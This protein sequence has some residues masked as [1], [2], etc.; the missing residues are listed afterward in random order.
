MFIKTES[1]TLINSDYIRVIF[2]DDDAKKH[3]L[4]AEVDNG[5]H[6]VLAKFASGSE[7][8]GKSI[9][10]LLEMLNEEKSQ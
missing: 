5:N 10:R 6:W 1:G 7:H 8:L 3:V 2:I 4:K 9:D